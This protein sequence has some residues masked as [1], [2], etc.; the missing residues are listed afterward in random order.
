MYDT[1]KKEKARANKCTDSRDLYN[2]PHHIGMGWEEL[3]FDD[4]DSSMS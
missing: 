2:L 1:A 4:D 3:A